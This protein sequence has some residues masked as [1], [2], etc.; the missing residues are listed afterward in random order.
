MPMGH[1]LYSDMYA[2]DPWTIQQYIHRLLMN[3]TWNSLQF[4][5]NTVWNL[6]Q[7]QIVF[8]HIQANTGNHFLLFFTLLFLVGFTFSFSGT[9][10]SADFFF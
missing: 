5:I 6:Q 1:G 10:L 7:L 4:Q 8:Q 3:I 9:S 2:H